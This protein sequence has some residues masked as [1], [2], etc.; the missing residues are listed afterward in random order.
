MANSKVNI[1]VDIDLDPLKK[2]ADEASEKVKNIG[3]NAKNSA[4]NGSKSFKTFASNLAKSLDVGTLFKNALNVVK[5]V[6][7][8][9]LNKGVDIASEKIKKIGAN[10]KKSAENGIKSFKA[11]AGNLVKSLGI[12]TLL[13]EGLQVVKDVLASNQKVVDFFSTAIGTLGDMVRDLFNYVSENAGVVVDYFKAIFED[14]LGALEDLGQAIKENLIERFVSFGETLGLIGKAVAEFFTGDFAQSWETL[15]EAGKE[16]IDVL[17]GVDDTVDKVVD[18]ATRAAEAIGNYAKKTWESNAALVDLQ[19]NAKLAAAQQARLAEQYDREAEL[20]RQTRDDERKSIADRIAANNQLAEV[21][22][23][24]EK[25][26][27]AAAQAQ[28]A[29]AQA[30]YNHNKTIDN[31]VALTQ[32]LGQA[33]GVRAKIAGL[34]SEQQMNDLALNKEENELLKV[35]A[36]ATNRLSLEAQK[37][38]AGRI[39]SDVLRLEALKNIAMKEREI[40]LK[41]LQ[42]QIDTYNVG[43]QA[44]VDAEIAYA[45]KK[46]EL[47]LQIKAQEDEIRKA[48]VEND[49]EQTEKDLKF[50]EQKFQLA[51]QGTQAL[52]DLNDALTANGVLNAKQS[53]KVNKSLQIAQ[54]TIAGYQSVNAVLADLTIPTAIRIPLAIATGISAFANVAKIAAMKYEGGGGAPTAPSS[55]S[56][57]GGAPAV[58]LSFLNQS[59]TGA[60]PVQAYVLAT[61]V[62]S[63][64]EAEQKIKDQSKIIK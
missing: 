55:N 33:D 21:L 37:F 27:L 25:A 61:N 18:T 53:F 2:G 11:F 15:K 28:V 34:R 42:E 43:T 36:E 50:Q 63:A 62:S 8:D 20:L 45:E 35:Q 16:S 10:A 64:Q 30:T 40:E 59:S 41:R 48:K 38:Y 24:Q 46:Q 44:R 22:D 23:K 49:K 12:I 9:P 52:M 19:N 29:A 5:D 31:Q 26:E 57:G 7:I 60:Q 14:P 3:K 58:D 13:S 39:K 56:G 1:E 17:T 6:F 51:S 54:A 47:D 32:A 4:E